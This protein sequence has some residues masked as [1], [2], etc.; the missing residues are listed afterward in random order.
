M[1]NGVIKT[2]GKISSTTIRTLA[3]LSVVVTLLSLPYL[4]YSKAHIHVFNGAVVAHW[5]PES[6]LEQATP[7]KK[8]PVAGHTH[9][10]SDLL[11]LWHIQKNQGDPEQQQQAL[12][13]Y[14]LTSVIPTVDLTNHGIDLFLSPSG[15]SPPACFA[16]L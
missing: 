9:S 14:S 7:D 4:H 15:R 10:L 5:H 2:L 11:N 16:V 6:G 8:T 12:V 13:F 3:T 1:S